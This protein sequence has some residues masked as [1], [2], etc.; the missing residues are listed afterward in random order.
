FA[1]QVENWD[2]QRRDEDLLLRGTQLQEIRQFD[3]LTE[4]EREFVKTS[5]ASLL[6]EAREK[7]E[8]R[9]RELEQAKALAA[10][11]VRVAQAER[12]RADARRREAVALK[13]RANA[14]ELAARR[15]RLF[16]TALLVALTLAVGAI[17]LF[18]RA[19]NAQQETNEAQQERNEAQQQTVFALE[20][21]QAESSTRIAALDEAEMAIAAQ[22]TAEYEQQEAEVMAQDSQ[23]EVA[24]LNADES[25]GQTAEAISVQT[26]GAVDATATSNAYATLDAQQTAEAIAMATANSSNNA[27]PTSR[28][29]QTEIIA[30]TVETL[31]SIALRESIRRDE[32]GMTMVLV[33][34][35]TFE[36]GAS[37][38][39]ADATS[40]E[41]P[42]HGVLLS[43]DFYIDQTEVT[44][45][46]YATFLNE[47]GGNYRDCDGNDC[48]LSRFDTIF[49]SLKQSL[50][51]SLSQIDGYGQT[52]INQVSWY[53]AKAYCEWAG[54]RLPTE[55]EWEYAARGLDGRIYPWGNE[56]PDNTRAVYNISGSF[57]DNIFDPLLEVDALPD[58]ISAF[59][60]YG[61][62]GGVWEWVQ[63]WYQEDYYASSNNSNNPVNM[64]DSSGLK[65][66]RGGSWES[67]AT[68]IRATARLGQAP[69]NESPRAYWNIGFRCAQDT[70]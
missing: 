23:A 12:E 11:Q 50:D 36:M 19:N 6:K 60:L 22:K 51:N 10:E 13:D 26:R 65:V 57:T 42:S 56:M 38:D 8:T 1:N 44:V 47:L 67:P 32:D 14:L 39:D 27:T 24:T 43:N 53:G 4:L 31:N 21:T 25:F 66:L 35:K 49:S 63:D 45:F 59:G 52:P 40:A 61:M 48:V 62:A 58:G 29:S 28:L 55:A 41:M 2:R 64:N 15:N 68:D 7:E 46:Q 3:D 30:V 37:A 34:G 20:T 69:A 54:A 9:Q 5:Q 18:I 33:T 70:N 16:N 17:F